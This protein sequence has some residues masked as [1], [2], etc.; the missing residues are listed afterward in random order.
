[1][2]PSTVIL[3]NQSTGYLT[4][5]IC[6]AF[7]KKYQKVILLAGNISNTPRP[8]K[9][10]VEIIK[11]TQYNKN[12]IFKRLRTWIKATKE[13][14]RFLDKYPGECDIVYFSNPP[15][16]YLKAYRRNS[17][18]A[19]VEYDIYPDVLQNIKCPRF[20][21]RKWAQKKQLAFEKSECIVTLG[22]SMKKQLEKYT[23]SEKIKVI[24]NWSANDNNQTKVS[25]EENDFS[26]K[27]NLNDKFIV[28]YSGNMGLT[29]NVDVL[30]DVANNLKSH[31]DIRFLIIGKAENRKHLE[32]KA[33]AYGISNVI[34]HDF[35]PTDKLKYSLS[36]A[37]L[38]AVILNQKSGSASIPSKTYN[39]LSYGVPLLNISPENSELWNLVKEYG[40]GGSFKNNDIKGISKFIIQCKDNR[41]ILSQLS[42]NSLKASERFT[43]KNAEEYVGIFE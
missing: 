1:M 27:L 14:N 22:E 3:V 31:D 8:L 6:N 28:M 7:A 35:L 41:E 26:S 17:R 15:M 42:T 30:I 13:I 37:D 39:L 11:I 19:I 34:F 12:S 5:D 40:C 18:Y 25:E 29:H 24:P 9:E 23:S 32:Q 21:I 38:G 33:A 4:V 36:C 2:N 16:S 43:I 20:I 10:N